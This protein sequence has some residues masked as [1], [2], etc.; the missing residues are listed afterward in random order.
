MWEVWGVWKALH[1]MHIGIIVLGKEEVK[2]GLHF[3]L[4]AKIHP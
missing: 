1:R 4:G 3:L 2:D